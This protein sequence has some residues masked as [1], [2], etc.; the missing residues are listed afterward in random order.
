MVKENNMTKPVR[1]QK[2][3]LFQDHG[4]WFVR[5]RE[6]VRQKDGTIK[7]RRQAKRLG[8]VRSFPHAD[9][10]EPLRVKFMQ[11]IN[12]DRSNGDSSMTLAEFVDC[13]YL[14]W[15]ESECRA[16]TSKGYRE[17]WENHMSA[18]IGE[19]RVRE[20]RTVHVG[21]MLR[22]IAAE[23][24]L[25]K[26]TLQHI[27]SVLSGIFTFAK[28]E[29]AFDG[30]NPVQGALLPSKAREAKETFAYDLSQ[31]LRILDVLPLLPKAAVA[32]ASFV[33][34]REG[35]LRGV[36]WPDYNGK[37]MTVCRSV[38]KSVVNRPKTAASRNSVPVI[39]ALATIL[40]EYRLS[41]HNPK[42]GVIFHSGNGSPMAMDKL[43][44]KVIRPAIEAIGLPWYG[45]HGFRRAIASNL[46]AL[47]ADDKVVQRV[48]RHAKP[49]VTR[50]RYI[51]VFD[52]AVLEAMQKMQ[53]TLEQLRSG[54]QLA[55]SLSPIDGKLLKPNRGEVAERLNAAVC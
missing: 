39:Q 55:S 26:N 45:W 47:G 20:V 54:Q 36:E 12:H 50:E 42:S 23:H 32:T 35:E 30:A 16:S 40:D 46:Y 7:F 48:L 38:W 43:A 29:G 33:G 49:H 13:S 21:R 19:L 51:K 4:A 2:G 27:K 1:Y 11:K 8:D 25:A 15:V 41:M 14:P 52:P 3:C 37:E 28:N 24:D 53:A 5:Y 9:D 31:I 18:R 6:S 34:L 17:L 22:A 10:I 44:Q